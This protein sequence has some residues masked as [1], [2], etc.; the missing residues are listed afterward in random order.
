MENPLLY[1][2]LTLIFE[3]SS[4][5]PVSYLRKL[6]NDSFPQSKPPESLP[7]VF[8]FHRKMRHT[9]WRQCKLNSTII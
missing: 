5:I 2:M 7:A 9:A 8:L 6:D 3:L 4:A 1:F